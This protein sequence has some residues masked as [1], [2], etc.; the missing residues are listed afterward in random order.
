V[1]SPVATGYIVVIAARA[2]ALGD[3]APDGFNGRKGLE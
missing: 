1:N 2:D 3:I